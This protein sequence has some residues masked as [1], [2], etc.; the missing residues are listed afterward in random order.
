MYESYWR[1]E[2]PAFRSQAPAE[3]F[4]AAHSQQAALL[5]LQY[6][7]EERQGIAVLTGQ[8]GAGKTFLLEAFRSQLPDSA[9]PIVD[10]LFP[11]L[12]SEE[13]LG[14][15]AAKLNDNFAEPDRAGD[16]LDRVL[17]RL[18]SQLARW[19]QQ[20]KHPLIVI[21]DAQLIEDQHVFHALQQLLNYRRTDGPEFSIVLCG[22]P[23]LVGQIR[24]HAALYER[25]AFVCA[26]QPLSE[27]ETGEY[28]RYRLRAAGGDE[29]IF[30]AASLH[31]I[32]HLSHGLPR[33]I[34][35]LCDFALLV[36]YADQLERISPTEIEA[37]AAELCPIAA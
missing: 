19:A 20:G 3:F 14:Y 32:H 21:D 12:T 9:G 26:V 16:R 8:A 15:L 10:V 7:V 28:I 35:R 22:Q 34:N 2:R 30:D 29:S 25:L 13:L 17:R 1:L 5:K 24:H 33:R 6:L 31:S 11:Q 18:E 27:E 23:E 37:V 36:G 4:F